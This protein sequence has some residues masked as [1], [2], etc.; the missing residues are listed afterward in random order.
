MK[1]MER[2]AWV[3]VV[4]ALAVWG[5]AGRGG[6]GG[7]LKSGREEDADAGLSPR[8]RERRAL[9]EGAGDRPRRERAGDGSAARSGSVRSRSM[10]A[11]RAADP[12]ARMSA[13]LQVLSS[14]DASGFE[15][16]REA[17]DEL[18]A[19]G[20]PLSGEE[21]LLHFRAGQLK[22]EELLADRTGKAEDFAEMENV[23]RQYEGWIQT[24]PHAA[25]RWLDGLPAGRFRDQM[26]VAY[27]AASTKEDPLGSLDLVATLHPSQQAAAGD[28][29]A[30]AATT[31]DAAALLRTLEART[32]GV[33]SPYMETM[34]T[35][36]AGKVAGGND[37]AA[38]SLIEEHLDQPYVSDSAVLMVSAA[39]AKFDPK[40]ALDWAVEMETRKPDKLDH[41]QVVAGVIQAM[42]LQ[43]LDTAERWAATQPDADE[44]LQVIGK[45]RE[46]LQDHEGD[47]NRY[48]RD[49]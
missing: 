1:K 49:D 12:V 45:R 5:M 20:V 44:L 34:F 31:E 16:V 21:E 25:G 27:I 18:K 17:L 2:I 43:G 40:G 15:Q 35:A 11:L 22:G 28:R 38:F 29:V 6:S 23:K 46:K 39:K 42:S 30:A 9:A 26:A 3:V 10:V 33:E 48:D 14:C 8:Q 7:G 37:P 19:A 36:L 47:E 32:G 4:L 13:F 24:D 41:G